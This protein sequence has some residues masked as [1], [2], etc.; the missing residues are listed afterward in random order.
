[1]HRNI[2]HLWSVYGVASLSKIRRLTNGCA[3][4]TTSGCLRFPKSILL[5]LTLQGCYSS[6][7]VVFN[8]MIMMPCRNLRP[9]VRCSHMIESL[10]A[11]W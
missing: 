9:H 6:F 4:S 11:H 8:H 5:L 2:Y 1:M 3:S 7:V 10:G